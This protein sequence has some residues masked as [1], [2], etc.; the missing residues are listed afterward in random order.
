MY[1]SLWSQ[2]STANAYRLLTYHG[3]LWKPVHYIW[4]YTIPQNCK[5]F[6][7]LAFKDRLN[8]KANMIN[9]KW[10]KDRHCSICAALESADHII[11]RCKTANN[12][13]K[14]IGILQLTNRSETIFD[15]IQAVIDRNQSTKG[16]EPIW[17]DACAYMLWKSRNNMVCER[18]LDHLQ[19]ITQ[20][21]CDTLNLWC[22]R[23]NEKTSQKIHSWCARLS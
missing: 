14:K 21:I 5:V 15:F 1:L 3:F 17:F 7:G 23:S 9:K 20:Q 12:L 22:L 18:Q 10:N 13:W 2:F 16:I 4:V 6:P 11:L 8:T 19:G